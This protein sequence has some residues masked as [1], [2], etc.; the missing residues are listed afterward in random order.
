MTG[1]DKWNP[2]SIRC[3]I[4]NE[5]YAGDVRHQKYFIPDYLTKTQK[6]NQGELPQYYV[7][8]NHA[9]IVPKK[10]YYLTQ[11]EFHRRAMHC[12]RNKTQ[13]ELFLTGIRCG[14]CGNWYR[15]ELRQK[16]G[17]LISYT[18]RCP[19]VNENGN[20]CQTPSVS[21]RKIK[22]SFVKAFNELLTHRD[23]I[24]IR[25]LK[26]A[27]RG[28]ET[29][30][31]NLRIDKLN[32]TLDHLRVL[33][34]DYPVREKG[35]DGYNELIAEYTVLERER[36]SLV[37]EVKEHILSC[38]RMARYRQELKK[39]PNTIKEFT[40]SLWTLFLENLTVEESGDMCFIF[41]DGTEIKV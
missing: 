32:D 34:D 24:M 30:R 27:D 36:D 25:T 1:S 23:E 26:N 38:R 35:I 20:R 18:F 8:N 6:R 16:K 41:K 7:E 14:C 33:M 12:T 22:S 5:K 4:Q 9:A 28:A 29:K 31:K 19:Y 10:I 40:P 2:C 21:E 39:L 15:A 13:D 37:S 3:M 11:A 17:E